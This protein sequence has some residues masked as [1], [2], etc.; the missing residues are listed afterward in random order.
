MTTL[1]LEEN[2]LEFLRATLQFPLSL[3]KIITYKLML[4]FIQFYT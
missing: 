3:E 4:T 1:H 2:K